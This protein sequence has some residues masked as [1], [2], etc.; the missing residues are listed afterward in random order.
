MKQHVLTPRVQDEEEADS[1]AKMFGISSDL[2]KSLG[3]SAD[4]QVVELDLVLS[5]ERMQLV[6]QGEHDM[7]VSCCQKLSFS[8]RD[9]TRL[10]HEL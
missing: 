8:G 7:E 9:P 1:R 3:H 2:Q 4:Q 5:D 10:R 6:R